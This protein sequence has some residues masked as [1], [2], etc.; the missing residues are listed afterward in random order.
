MASNG[1]FSYQIEKSADDQFG[2][3]VTTIKCHGSLVSDTSGEIRDAVKPL[4][5][6]GG[7]II[8]DFGDLNYL[9][10]SGLGTLVG[11]KA[12]A[13]RQGLCRLELVNM[14]PRILELLR[15]T[16]LMNIFS[17]QGPGSSAS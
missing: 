17:S 12:T 14:T 8:L 2:N 9:D 3:K 15:I 7:R 10:S 16:N 1:S 13:V 5:P 11:L 6:Q 4:I